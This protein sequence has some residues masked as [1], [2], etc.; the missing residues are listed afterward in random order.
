MIADQ[1]RQKFGTTEDAEEH[2]ESR[3][4]DFQFRRSFFRRALAISAIL[5]IPRIQ[6]LASN[7]KKQ[8]MRKQPEVEKQEHV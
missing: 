1:E 2:G 8:S 4:E 6:L 7:K 5:A 3:A